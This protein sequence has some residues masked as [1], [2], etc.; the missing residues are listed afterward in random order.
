MSS[1][2]A[3]SLHFGWN[4]GYII[5]KHSHPQLSLLACS[6]V[7]KIFRLF[8]ARQSLVNIASLISFIL[9]PRDD[10]CQNVEDIYLNLVADLKWELLKQDDAASNCELPQ[11]K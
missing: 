3:K 1:F 9:P 8:T 2:P 7:I 10:D 4:I 6:V 11:W 5:V